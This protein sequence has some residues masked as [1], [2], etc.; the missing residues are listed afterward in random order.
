VHSEATAVGRDVSTLDDIRQDLQLMEN[1]RETL[2]RKIDKIK[3]RVLAI[4]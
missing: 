1:E 4:R 3:R 2:T